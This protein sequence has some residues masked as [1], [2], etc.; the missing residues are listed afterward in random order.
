MIQSTRNENVSIITLNKPKVNAIDNDML[1]M[2]K[3]AI[4]DATADTETNT[5]LITG[6]GSFFSFGLDIPTFLTLQR[7][8]LKSSI[9]KL[10]EVCKSL[11]LS[12]KITIASINGH[13][14]GAGCMIALSCDFK[15]MV[16]KRAK[17][18]LNEINIGLSLFSSTIYMLKNSIGLNNAKSLLLN[19]DLINPD[20]ALAIGLVDSLHPKEELLEYSLQLGITFKDKNN[21][22]IE[23]MKQELLNDAIG[24][25]NDSDKSIEKFLDIFYLEETQVILKKIVVRK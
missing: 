19:G 16:D 13:A 8:Q 14:T 2:L 24:Q 12:R 17:I 23:N 25:L 11:Y 21:M 4:D 10:L 6:S 7:S 1:D 3:K 5:L 18:A 20:E 9:Y 22:I 15:N